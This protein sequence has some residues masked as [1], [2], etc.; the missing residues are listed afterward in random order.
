MTYYANNITVIMKS[1][2]YIRDLN[3]QGIWSF[4]FK[5]AQLNLGKDATASIRVLRKKGR[6]ID[7]ARGFYVII[8]EEMSLTGRLPAE[9]FINDLMKFYNVSYYIGLLS[10]ASFYGAAH[11]SPQVLQVVTDPPRRAIQFGQNKI[12]FY[13]KKDLDSTPIEM[14]KTPT[15]YVK[16]STTEATF[17][18]MIQYNHRI[19]GL[20][21]VALVTSELIER[22][23]VSG[24]KEAVLAFP[25]PILQ[26]GGFLLETL[27]FE[28]GAVI[29]EN[30]IN[31]NNPIYTY[32]NPTR[33]KMREPKHRRW[34]L[35]VNDKIDYTE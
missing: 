35:I 26:R 28:K 33:G 30:L 20:D 22:F 11:Q 8:P 6:I 17:F 16:I 23:S 27:G 1:L 5:E 31:K 21:H 15:G 34:K 9:R 18:D 12:T 7:P 19:G 24:L 10:A 14:R 32:L 29:L 2:D 4:T 3:N 25:F 13:R